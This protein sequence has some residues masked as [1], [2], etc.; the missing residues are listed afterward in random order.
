MLESM[1]NIIDDIEISGLGS[2]LLSN[3]TRAFRVGEV[4]VRMTRC[5]AR[6]KSVPGRCR[7]RLKFGY[8]GLHNLIQISNE[9][10][11]RYLRVP[12]RAAVLSYRHI[13]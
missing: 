10:F 9:I 7:M 3:G 4:I 13:S 1:S 11:H 5:N 8:R 12:V 6:Q 2:E